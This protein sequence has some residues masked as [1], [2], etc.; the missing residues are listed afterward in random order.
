[1]KTSLLSIIISLSFVSCT[2]TNKEKVSALVNEAKLNKAVAVES[3][4]TTNG[5]EASA[6]VS[7]EVVGIRPYMAVVVGWERVVK[8]ETIS[9]NELTNLPAS[10]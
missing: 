9:N 10:K 7:T 8:P 5:Y 1:M 2:T 6:Y 3:G 4:E